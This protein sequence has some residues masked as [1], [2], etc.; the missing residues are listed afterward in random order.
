VN[1]VK[2]LRHLDYAVYDEKLIV[3]MIL[4]DTEGM[5]R[6]MDDSEDGTCRVV[7]RDRKRNYKGLTK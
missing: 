5:L 1:A 3:P 4:V 7:F 6:I 2:G